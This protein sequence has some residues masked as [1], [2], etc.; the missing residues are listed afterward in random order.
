MY[1]RMGKMERIA[2]SKAFLQDEKETQSVYKSLVK[3]WTH[4]KGFHQFERWYKEKTTMNDLKEFMNRPLDTSELFISFAVMILIVILLGWIDQQYANR[5]AKKFPKKHTGAALIYLYIEDQPATRGKLNCVKGTASRLFSVSAAQ[6]PAQT[7]GLAFYAAPGLVTVNLMIRG[8]KGE[9]GSSLHTGQLVFRAETNGIYRAQL[10]ASG[11][12]KM[13]LL[14]GRE[15]HFMQQEKGE[16]NPHQY[17]MKRPVSADIIR[18]FF[19]REFVR[20]LL[21]SVILMLLLGYLVW[22]GGLPKIVLC[23]PGALWLLMLCRMT[24]MGTRNFRREFD[25]LPEQ[26]REHIQIDFQK[27]HPIY[28]LFFGEVHLLP[29]CLICRQ[30]GQLC[31]LPLEQITTLRSIQYSKTYGLSKSLMIQMNTGRKYQLEFTTS[32]QKEIPLVISWIQ[33]KNSS[34][35]LL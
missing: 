2:E 22:I 15:F 19:I 23:F 16:E 5:K 7:K 28:K 33:E 20:L 27:P 11:Q 8:R 6:H 14:K 35:L 21:S 31:L 12:I 13:S 9:D 10:Y 30:R 3:R 4:A 26:R 1:V 18:E 34:T 25:A 29:D 17:T 32:R 24:T